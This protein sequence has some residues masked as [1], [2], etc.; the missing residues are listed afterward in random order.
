[1][2][3]MPTAVIAI[4]IKGNILFY[5]SKAASYL[6]IDKIDKAAP[7]SLVI[8]RNKQG[9]AV[10]L[11][12][13]AV[14]HNE[15]KLQLKDTYV[16]T[17]NEDTVYLGVDISPILTKHHKEEAGFILILRDITKEKS[18]DEERDEF[19]SVTYHELRTPLATAEGSLSMLLD[20]EIT[21]NITDH[22]RQQ[23][24]YTYDSI[25][26]LSNVTNQLAM[27]SQAEASNLKISYE[28]LDAF[29]LIKKLEYLFLEQAEKKSL[30]LV[31]LTEPN[32][33][34][35]RTSKVYVEEILKN[36]I[37]NAIKFTDEGTITIKV[38]R[39]VGDDSIT[40]TVSDTGVGI[41][42]RDKDSVFSK[43]YRA[44]DYRTRKNGGTGLGLYLSSKLAG[45]ISAKMEFE[46]ELNKGSTFILRVP[47]IS[48]SSSDKI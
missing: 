32:T 19:I 3:N 23:I 43:Y 28:E 27:L 8:M 10:N 25:T 46:S 35:I 4:D 12:S 42:E 37:S 26:Y 21:V 47:N 39:I 17:D 30:Q 6:V 11:A 45:Y 18:L 14:D 1:M 5:N 7:P 22:V 24:Q 40:F 20:P 2:N 44:E 34:V 36:L 48:E 38:G 29:I 13:L 16:Y 41:S 33:G 31:I 15:D 9:V